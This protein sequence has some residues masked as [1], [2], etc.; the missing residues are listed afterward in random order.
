M[1]RYAI[2]LLD[3][4][5]VAAFNLALQLALIRLASSVDYGV[6]VLWQSMVMVLTGFQDAMIGMPLSLRIAYDRLNSRRFV[7]E[8]QVAAFAAL[9]IAAG[10][11]I[12]LGAVVLTS[13]GSDSPFVLG[14]AVAIYAATFLAYYG[15]R[16]LAQSRAQFGAAL[17][18][19]SVYAV[20]SLALLGTL[21][22]SPAPFSLPPIFALLAIPAAI[23][24]VTGLA[25]LERP[26]RPT[27]RRV[28]RR[29][30]AIW[31]DSRWTVAAVAAA[32]TQN[33]AFIFVITAFYGAA[34]LAG[35]FAAVLVLRHLSMLTVAWTAFARPFLVGMRE[36][37]DLNGMVRFAAI[38]A[39]VLIGG[40]AIN[41]AL[42]S[43]AWPLV[44][45][46]IYGVKYENM[47]PVVQLWTLIYALQVPVSVL[48]LM[49]V[50]LGR[51]REDSL[52]VMGGSVVTV[53]LVT[54]LA[55]FE[56]PR[57]AILGM[58]AG[59]AVTAAIMG[60]RVA[61]ELGRRRSLIAAANPQPI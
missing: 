15:V 57:A 51:Y 21:A 18:M 31:R 55:A 48:A 7:L 52:A 17:V 16:F 60:W 23:A 34:A 53:T 43:L 61:A 30:A 19:D 9:F 2:P 37:R 3:Q 10:A 58:G 39:G 40:Y 35:V 1:R 22:L 11:C 41:L 33:R 25:V 54:A 45:T 6:F 44:E 46:Y 47:F 14:P 59:Y 28:L 36:R 42:L 38:S 4:C 24:A 20:L 29:Y 50:T 26:P 12:L 8:R 49:L 5:V 32:E 56:G 27:F 13:E